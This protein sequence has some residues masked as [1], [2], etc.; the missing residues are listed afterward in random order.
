MVSKLA[1]YGKAEALLNAGG[2]T[3]KIKGPP[4]VLYRHKFELVSAVIG[5]LLQAKIV[6][7]GS[8]A[9]EAMKSKFLV[10]PEL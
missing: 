8:D 3:L 6:V 5:A 10:N 9:P 1:Y 4:E 2:R 7:I